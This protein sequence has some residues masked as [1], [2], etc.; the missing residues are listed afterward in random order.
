MPKVRNIG[1][2]IVKLKLEGKSHRKIAKILNCSRSVVSYHV[3]PGQK[4]KSKIRG[5]K[6]SKTCPYSKKLN[7][8]MRE[9]TKS[10]QKCGKYKNINEI[11][12]KKIQKFN[13]RDNNSMNDCKITIKDI[14]EKFTLTP[15]CYLTGDKIDIYNTKSYHFDHILPSSRGGKSTFDNLGIC[16]RQANLAKSDST[17]EEH[18]E[19]CK[20]VLTNNG[21]NISKNTI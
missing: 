8:F 20:K 6:Y 16:T 14:V 12:Y 15:K 13:L 5:K 21:Y 1:P 4:L 18:I 19:Y 11:I 7:R 17:V 3:G 10:R 2:K 9:N